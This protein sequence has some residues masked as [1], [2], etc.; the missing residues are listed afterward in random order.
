MAK[1]YKVYYSGWYIV[2]ADSISEALETDRD[3][4]IYEEWENTS[5]SLA[6]EENYG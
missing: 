2:E 6:K 1:K 3:D 5:A 4:G